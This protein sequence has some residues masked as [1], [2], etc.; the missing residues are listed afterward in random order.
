MTDLIRLTYASKT[1]ASPNNVQRDVIDIL[2]Q[3]IQFNAKHSISG[4]LFYNNNYFFQCL[5]GERQQLSKLYEK[6]VKDSRH[7][8]VVQLACE[9]IGTAAFGEWNMKYILE[10]S[11]IRHFFVH[12]YGQSFNPYLLNDGLYYEFIQLLRD[13]PAA[14][15]IELEVDSALK[16]LEHD[17]PFYASRS[18]SLF[19]IMPLIII[20]LIFYLMA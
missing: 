6:I 11:R 3:S 18:F 2:H 4:V 8:E 13:S 17:K 7:M 1:T 20:S 16:N 10:D 9:S 5:E 12:Y 19:V 14:E 15:S